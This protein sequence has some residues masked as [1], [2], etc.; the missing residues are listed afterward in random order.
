MLFQI[1]LKWDLKTLKISCHVPNPSTNN[2]YINKTE[3]STAAKK[4]VLGLRSLVTD[5]NAEKHDRA[6]LVEFNLVMDS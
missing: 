4:K 2:I 1:K 3:R 5:S 6:L